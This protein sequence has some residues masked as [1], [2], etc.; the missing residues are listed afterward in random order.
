MAGDWARAFSPASV[1]NVGVGFDI[2][3]HTIHGPR[4]HARVRRIAEPTVR[5]AA[6]EGLPMALPMEPARN[7]AGAALQS[8]RAVLALPF[9]FELVLEKGLPLGSGMG[10]S[11]ASCVAALVAANALLDAPLAQGDLYPHAIAGERLASGGDNGDNVG[12]MLL[13][14]LVLAAEGRLVPLAVPA[15]WH[16]VLVHPG[17]ALETLRAREV[18]RAPY[19]LGEV[20]AQ[21]GHLALLLAG[22]ARGDAALVRAGLQDRLVEP[23]RAPLVPGF[24]AVKAAALQAGALGCSLSG[25]GPSVFAWFDSRAGAQAA[26]APMQAGFAAAG[27]ESQAW[28]SPIAGP[29]AALA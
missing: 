16:C 10:G 18:L 8:L 6:I 21:T 26:V 1:G 19:G 9:G 11:A 14:G 2:L 5:I 3:G 24:G 25:A 12:P 22:C 20:V 23:R 27:V 28:V 13:G 4:D 29:A 17:Q 15:D 7:T